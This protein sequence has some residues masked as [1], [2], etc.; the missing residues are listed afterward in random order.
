MFIFKQSCEFFLRGEKRK[1]NLCSP[2]STL[3]MERIP[4]KKINK[5]KRVMLIRLKS[6]NGCIYFLF[7][8]LLL[9]QTKK[10]KGK[11]F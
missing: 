8:K 11:P 7:G 6:E 5:K 2:Y 1:K 4:R 10:N 9:G 3:P